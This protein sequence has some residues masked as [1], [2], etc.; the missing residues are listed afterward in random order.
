M[1]YT[2]ARRSTL[3]GMLASVRSQRRRENSQDCPK[4]PD[5]ERW[6][7]EEV[8]KAMNVVSIYASRDCIAERDPTEEPSWRQGG[9]GGLGSG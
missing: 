4:H 8:A 5:R 6:E 2:R 3:S 1:A 7:V 9:V